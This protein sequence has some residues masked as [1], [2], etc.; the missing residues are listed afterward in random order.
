MI[1]EEVEVEYALFLNTFTDT[2]QTLPSHAGDDEGSALIKLLEDTE[3]VTRIDNTYLA[4]NSFG[5][6]CS[7][8]FDKNWRNGAHRNAEEYIEDFGDRVKILYDV[9][10]KPTIN[11]YESHLKHLDI[12]LNGGKVQFRVIG[13]KQWHNLTKGSLQHITRENIEFRETPPMIVVDDISFEHKE[14]AIAFIQNK[15]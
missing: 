1:A 13:S 5:Q 6:V 15:Y 9:R 2:V 14:D 10:S 3:V 7:V 12:F 8:K 11:E 4:W